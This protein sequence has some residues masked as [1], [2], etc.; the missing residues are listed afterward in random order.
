MTNSY[1]LQKR[2][3]N[4]CQFGALKKYSWKWTSRNLFFFMTPTGQD[5]PTTL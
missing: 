1:G 5:V 2:L 4:K 3:S